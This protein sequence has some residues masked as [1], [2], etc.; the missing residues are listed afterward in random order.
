VLF[1]VTW[2]QRL[3]EVSGVDPLGSNPRLDLN[4]RPSDLQPDAMTFRP[5]QHLSVVAE[6]PT[7]GL[8]LLCITCI[9][10]G[11][12]GVNKE[13]LFKDVLQYYSS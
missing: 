12:L 3:L 10:E 8:R 5:R 9:I 1:V 11:T 4:F 6:N 2:G 7:N 13:Q